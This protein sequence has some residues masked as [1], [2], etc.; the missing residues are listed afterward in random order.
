[1]LDY[2]SKEHGR[3]KSGLGDWQDKIKTG[4]VQA[5]EPPPEDTPEPLREI[6]ATWGYE[7]R[8]AALETPRPS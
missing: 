2:G 7:P 1:M 3:F 4:Q 5:P 8:P 6:A